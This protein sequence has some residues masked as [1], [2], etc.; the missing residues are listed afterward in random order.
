MIFESH[1]LNI[2]TLS[3]YLTEIRLKLGLSLEQ[4]VEKTGVCMKYLEAI[5]SGQYHLLPP[6]VYVIGFLKQIAQAYSLSI[7]Q[8]IEQYKKERGIV[9]QAVSPTPKPQSALKKYISSVSITPKFVSVM[10]GAAFI[11]G[12]VGYLAFQVT[13]ISKAPALTIDTPLANSKVVGAVVTVTGQTEPGTTLHINNQSVMV[14]ND[15]RFQTTVSLMSGQTELRVEAKNKFDHDTT[16]IIPLV[17]DQQVP[18]VAGAETVV[19][20]TLALELEFISGATIVVT[21]DGQV[22]PQEAISEGSTKYIRGNEAIKLSS[23][24]A[25]AVRVRLNGQDLGLLGK[26]DQPITDVLF[27]SDMLDT[28]KK[29]AS[30]DAKPA[31]KPTAGDRASN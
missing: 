11:V 17:V 18:R 13:S 10:M 31:F 25:G 30:E 29:P 8:L 27:T 6:D 15:G 20:P 9:E 7:D 26:N 16:K 24:N 28:I 12:T 14:Q 22:L 5:E 4:A 23:S 3:E 21:V 2:D 19:E 1:K